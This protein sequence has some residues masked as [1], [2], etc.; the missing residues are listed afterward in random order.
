MMGLKDS[1]DEGKTT[2]IQAACRRSWIDE[3]NEIEVET[4]TNLQSRSYESHVREHPRHESNDGISSFKRLKLR[5]LQKPPPRV[6]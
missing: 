3:N 6:K 2:F 4:I 1:A 5:S